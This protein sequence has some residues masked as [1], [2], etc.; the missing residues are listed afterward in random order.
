MVGLLSPRLRSLMTISLVQ[1]G[2]NGIAIQSS[3]SNTILGLGLQRTVRDSHDGKAA[4]YCEEG[5]T[6]PSWMQACLR[7]VP[8]CPL[9]NM[10]FIHSLSPNMQCPQARKDEAIYFSIIIEIEVNLI[11]FLKV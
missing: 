9:C 5:M 2:I 11:P 4:L 1:E 6:G 7:A 10:K 3:E 8:Q